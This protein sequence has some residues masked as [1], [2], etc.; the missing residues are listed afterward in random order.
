MVTVVWSAKESALKA[1]RCG[2][3]RDTRAVELSVGDR[4]LDG[5]YSLAVRDRESA[6]VLPGWWR[7]VDDVVVT[8]VTSAATPPPTLAELGRRPTAAAAMT[9]G[10]GRR[11]SSRHSRSCS[12]ATPWPCGRSASRCSRSASGRTGSW[13]QPFSELWRCSSASSTGGPAQHAF[14]TESLGVVDLLTV[15]VVSTAAFWAVE[16]EKLVRRRRAASRPAVRAI[17]FS[18]PQ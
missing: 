7:S 11:C 9:N 18:S 12:L 13:L 16:A 15:L 3:R 6:T 8:V 5:W 1:L 10:R 14:A 17:G 4:I 2:L